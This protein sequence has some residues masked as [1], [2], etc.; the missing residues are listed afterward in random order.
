[1]SYHQRRS[2][3]LRGYNYCSS[4]IYF[5]TIRTKDSDNIFG[6]IENR[7]VILNKFGKIAF[8]DWINIS[9]I[10]T[11]MELDTFVIMPDHIHGIIKILPAVGATDPVAHDK[12]VGIIDR[13]SKQF[14]NKYDDPLS[15]KKFSLN[16]QKSLQPNSLSSIIG[17]YKSVVTKKIHNMGF[18]EFQWQRNYY[19]R[20]LFRPY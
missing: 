19:R 16:F 3:R 2:I 20:Y 12:K 8:D 13:N 11:D 14:F 6:Y 10:R 17:Q 9:Q 4:G 5:V 1:M 18:T 7:K 15:H